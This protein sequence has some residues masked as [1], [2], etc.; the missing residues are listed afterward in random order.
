MGYRNFLQLRMAVWRELQSPINKSTPFEID[1]ALNDSLNEIFQFENWSF[2]LDRYDISL[3]PI[4]NTGTVNFTNGST[5][6]TGVGTVWNTGWYNTKIIMSGDTVEKQVDHYTSG[7]AGVLRYPLTS[8][9]TSITGV[10][11]TIYQDE[12]PIPN[13]AANKDVIIVN[14][15]LRYR[16]RHWVRYTSEDRTVFS[17]FISGIRFTGPVHYT[18]AGTDLNVNSPTYQQNLI[19]V[20]PPPMVSQ[21]LILIY[22]RAFAPLVADTDTTILPPQFEE[23][24][25]DL[26]V[27]RL[28]KRYGTPGWMEAR[29]VASRKLL[30]M[31]EQHR[32]ADSYDHT[33][34]FSSYPVF[35]P[36]QT[37]IDL[38]I[39]PGIIA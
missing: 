39:W 31:R 19:K 24:L 33:V 16:L 29:E 28:K 21:N 12:Y 8:T 25:I 32:S 6:F 14:P 4:Y 3:F 27:Y 36:Y 10:G 1:E 22:Y 23:I 15:V 5:A 2:L 26:A 20:W 38:V 35:D 17:R 9:A 7:T 18:E 37:D 13:F 11:Y 34:E 30:E